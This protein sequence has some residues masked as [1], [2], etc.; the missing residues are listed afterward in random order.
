MPQT[1][2]KRFNTT[3]L[4]RLY[5]SS[6]ADRQ[7]KIIE[8]INDRIMSITDLQLQLLCLPKIVDS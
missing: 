6:I 1:I 2:T 4:S 3:V 8:I 5:G 7:L